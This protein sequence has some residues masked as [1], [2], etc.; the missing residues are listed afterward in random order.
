MLRATNAHLGPQSDIVEI[1]F[2]G[3]KLIARRGERL[4]AALM[5]AGEYRLRI[6]ASGDMRGPFC[7]MGVCQECLVEVDGV[8]AQ[9]ACLTSVER[10]MSVRRQTSHVGVV[11]A[12]EIMATYEVSTAMDMLMPQI[13]VIGGGPAG[14]AAAICAASAG[15]DVLLIDERPKLGGQFYKQPLAA[16]DLRPANYDDHQFRGGRRL[17]RQLQHTGATVMSGAKVVGAYE[18]LDLVVSA[19]SKTLLV[20][21][22]ILIV[23]AG[24][25]EISFPFKGWTLPGVMTTGAAQTL[26]RSYRVLPGKRVLIAGNGPLN[27]Q[28]AA[29]LA[30]SGAEILAVIEAAKRPA[31]SSMGAIS[32]MVMSAPNLTLKG[33]GYVAA[34]LHRRASVIYGQR[35]SQVD[36]IGDRTPQLRATVQNLS[37]REPDTHVFDVDAVCLGYGFSPSNEILRALGCRHDANPDS[38]ALDTFRD[39]DCRTSRDDVFAVGD[40]TRLG[41]APMARAEGVIAATAALDALGISQSAGQQKKAAHMRASRSHHWRFQRALW[42]LFEPAGRLFD[43]IDEEALVCRCEELTFAALR[44]AMSEHDWISMGN[45]KRATRA[46]MGRCQGRYCGASIARLFAAQNAQPIEEADLWAPRPPTKPVRIADL[47]KLGLPDDV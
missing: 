45:L 47:A 20:R 19:K 3:R 27:F 12:P 43:H 34:L 23:A 25:Y 40:C 9:R 36:A 37:R 5:A 11:S 33:A 17:I 21:P 42:T 14:M 18:P 16:K 39:E 31:P 41:G 10:A 38:G 24:A 1:D 13:A 30:K 28:V 15:A 2:H 29:E 22:Q 35:I 32:R 44:K 7:G 8:P 6:T 46:G 26:L 4:L